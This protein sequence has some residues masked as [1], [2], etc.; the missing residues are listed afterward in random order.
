MGEVLEERPGALHPGR[1]LLEPLALLC[2]DCLVRRYGIQTMAMKQLRALVRTAAIQGHRAARLALFV[3]L[4]G[5]VD[6]PPRGPSRRTRSG[7]TVQPPLQNVSGA[8]QKLER[9]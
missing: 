4:V 1:I 8:D 9:P 3:S 6:F 5:A 2:R 7:Q